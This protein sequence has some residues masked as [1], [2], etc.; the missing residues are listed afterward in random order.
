MTFTR[1]RIFITPPLLPN[2]QVGLGFREFFV[3]GE[4]D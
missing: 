3:G 1:M 4:Y 2:R